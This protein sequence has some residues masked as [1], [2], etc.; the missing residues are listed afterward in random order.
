VPDIP[1]FNE[2]RATLGRLTTI[3][4]P[5]AASPQAA[6][7]KAAATSLTTLSEVSPAALTTW[8]ADHPRWINVLGLAVGLSQ[9]KLKNALKDH[10]NTSGWVALASEHPGD[11]VAML[12]Q[13]FDLVRLIQMQR[14]RAYD[15][16]DV[17]VARAGTRQTATAAGAS[18]RKVEDEIEAIAANL[19]LPYQTRTRF[20]GRN[21]RTA[22][23][24]LVIPTGDDAAIAVAA[25][26]FDSTGTILTNAGREIEEMADVRLPT[27]FI[28]A[29][30]DGIGWKSR[31]GDLRRIYTLW[32]RRQIDG[33]YTLATLDRFRD[34]LQH[35]ARLR[36]LLPPGQ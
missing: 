23:C 20:T 12:E 17:L 21:H 16:G 6:E 36:G 1:T 10:F 26:G 33:M 5:T 31:G 2:Y 28:M 34:D 13:E 29:V 35:A 32:E 7:I 8:A 19:G 18:G 4:D 22:P 15:F 30:I 9:E 27:Q 25:K 14:N 11:L 24:D 3:A